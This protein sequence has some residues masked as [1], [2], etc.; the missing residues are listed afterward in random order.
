MW[1]V[2]IYYRSNVEGCQQFDLYIRVDDPTDI[3]D[4]FNSAVDAL[5]A[6][7]GQRY[8][9]RG[10]REICA[11]EDYSIEIGPTLAQLS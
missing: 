8:R 6:R 10:G 5:F 9:G 4:V 3:V 2:L 1:E 7:Q 11:P